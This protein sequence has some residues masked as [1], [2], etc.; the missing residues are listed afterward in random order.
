[1]ASTNQPLSPQADPPEPLGSEPVGSRPARSDQASDAVGREL[2]VVEPGRA[3][4]WVVA[5][6]VGGLATAVV[7]GSA[8]VIGGM[9]AGA[10]GVNAV[11]LA[12]AV[13]A[14][15]MAWAWALTQCQRA[16]SRRQR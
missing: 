7:G 10:Q 15:G 8:F 5:A 4:P 3:R 11:L 13:P 9:L 1:M 16:S 2:D 14:A 6:Y 12:A